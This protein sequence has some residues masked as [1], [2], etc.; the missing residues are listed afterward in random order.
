LGFYYGVG[1]GI[2]VGSKTLGSMWLGMYLNRTLFPFPR[3]FF[4]LS[5]ILCAS[6]VNL[7]N[8]QLLMEEMM[9]EESSTKTKVELVWFSER[10]SSVRSPPTSAIAGQGK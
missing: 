4:K 5:R 10:A 7:L 1:V 9:F 6:L 3:S 8:A 2:D